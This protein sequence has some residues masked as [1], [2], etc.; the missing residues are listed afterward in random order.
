[1]SKVKKNSWILG[2]RNIPARK[3][4]SS[5]LVILK[6]TSIG[7]H[8]IFYRYYQCSFCIEALYCSALLQPVHIEEW[9]SL[10]QLLSRVGI[11]LRILARN[12]LGQQ[13]VARVV[14]KQREVNKKSITIPYRG[15]ISSLEYELETE[16]NIGLVLLAHQSLLFTPLPPPSPSLN[17]STLLPLLYT[18]SQLDLHAIIRQQQ[19][20]LAAMQ[21][22]L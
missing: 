9:Q 12:F 8:I 18:M 2:L 3:G 20:Q 13:L 17:T 5:C 6:P 14:S 1:M 22:Q 19:K 4:N 11:F 21:A 15:V 16:S 10:L 7:R